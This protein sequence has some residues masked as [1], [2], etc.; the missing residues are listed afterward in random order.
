MKACHCGKTASPHGHCDGSHSLSARELAA[1]AA[2]IKQEVNRGNE[3]LFPIPG[4]GI[5]KKKAKTGLPELSVIEVPVLSS[6]P[7]LKHWVE[8]QVGKP[9]KPE[10][11]PIVEDV[12]ILIEN[13][14][15]IRQNVN[16]AGYYDRLVSS[17][18]GNTV[19]YDDVIT[20]H[21]LGYTTVEALSFTNL[22][23]GMRGQCDR[24]GP[25]LACQ[26]PQKL[27][28]KPEQ[29]RE[30]DNLEVAALLQDDEFD[31]AIIS[32]IKDQRQYTILGGRLFN[33]EN[34]SSVSLQEL[35]EMC[36]EMGRSPRYVAEMLGVYH[37]TEAES[38]T[39]LKRID[40]GGH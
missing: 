20:L 6:E 23:C 3:K 10:H 9:L 5:D 40:V 7:T 17:S 26:S 31:S 1:R 16:P 36:E 37:Q 38:H 4:Q 30:V 34:S 13:G 24:G 28:P 14:A 27:V 15:T 25:C 19:S 11:A 29:R 12:K 33:K 2:G 32:I 35:R 8:Q 22:L 18:N 21:N 39:A